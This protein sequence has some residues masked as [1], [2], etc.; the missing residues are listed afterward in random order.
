MTH[1]NSLYSYFFGQHSIRKYLEKGV[2]IIN[3]EEE[4]PIPP[5]GKT[6]NTKRYRSFNFEFS[7]ALAIYP[8]NPSTAAGWRIDFDYDDVDC[9]Y[10]TGDEF[11]ECVE[12]MS[13]VAEDVLINH[14]SS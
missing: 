4:A 9:Q 12:G 11:I 1:L 14:N 7:L 5:P 13:Y 3:Q 6:S 2:F 8:V 10:L